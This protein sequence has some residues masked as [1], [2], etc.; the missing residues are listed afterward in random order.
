M[1]QADI[2]ELLTKLQSGEDA[3]RK[4]AIFKLQ[5]SI[6]DPSIAD[7]FISTGGLQVLRQL[8][9]TT[10]GNTLAYALSAL[11]R[12]LE[13]EMGWEI[14]ESNGAEALV[15]RLVGLIVTHPLV[16]ILRGAMSI[17]VAVVGHSQNSKESS[18]VPGI[19]GFR[20]LKPAIAVY[21]QFF[22]MV[23]SQLKSADHLLCSNAL[24]LL[25][26]LIRDVITRA[27][28]TEKNSGESSKPHEN[29]P[30]LI[31][32]LQDLGIVQTA[33]D[34][35]QSSSHQD[36]AYS[37]LEFQAVSKLI[38]KKRRETVVNIENLE[39]QSMLE[40]IYSS[41]QK[42]NKK[43]VQSTIK[44]TQQSSINGKTNSNEQNLEMWRNLGFQT[45]SPILEFEQTGV[46]G[47][48]DLVHFATSNEES[49]QK[50]LQE[51]ETRPFNERCP[52]G[53]A[54]MSVTGILYDHFDIE[55][56]DPEYIKDYRAIDGMKNYADL[57]RPFILQWPRIHVKALNSFIVLWKQVGAEKQEFGKVVELLRI[58]VDKV[59]RGVSRTKDIQEIEEEL[60]GL[61]A[62]QLRKIQMEILNTAFEDEWEQH[63]FQIREELRNE[64]LQFMKE[65]RIRTLLN[66][67][68]FPRTEIN[69]DVVGAQDE[70]THSLSWRYVRLSN[71]RRYLHYDDFESQATNEPSINNLSQ[72][73]DLENISSVASN[74]SA[75]SNEDSSICTSTT[76]ATAR[77]SEAQT[78][79]T[80]ITIRCF[81]S[82]KDSKQRNLDTSNEMVK[83]KTALILMP[84]NKNLAS[85]WLDGLLMLLDQAPITPET[86]KLVDFICDYGLK[87]RLLNVRMD[88]FLDP[89]DGAG[90]IPSREG[91]DEDYFYEM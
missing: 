20:A 86:I 80:G 76:A 65:Q 44:N 27:E 13:V 12:L 68:W 75:C 9:M 84:A 6:N 50:Y 57:F 83:E 30:E 73:I 79:A 62:R 10:S 22:E 70:H 5:T 60:T 89:P 28:S 3:I 72:K 53:R 91:L 85:S 2:P 77:P 51:Q 8:I 35:M 69:V 4:L 26:A 29:W 66:G 19:F 11:S 48:M 14:F 64:A 87:I 67:A 39:H 90:V 37:L 38:L 58:L 31:K 52:I 25:N 34:L 82:I 40:K 42:K 7:V 63:L 55:R 24:M 61:D 88:D 15:E 56:S 41:S 18:Q 36:M 17:L 49:Y 43:E 47:M 71:D 23:V 45:E 81:V 46:L 21:P 78:K 32:K 59:L 33:Y 54:S 74:T 1:N 16:N